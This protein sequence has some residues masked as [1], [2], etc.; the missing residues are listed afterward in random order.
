[1][2]KG[3][4]YGAPLAEEGAR[5]AFV[6]DYSRSVL[7]FTRETGVP[8][9]ITHVHANAVM[10]KGFATSSLLFDILA[11]K[12]GRVE[13]IGIDTFDGEVPES[14]F[15]LLEKTTTIWKVQYMAGWTRDGAKTQ[16]L[17]ECINR[18]AG[19]T[20][21]AIGKIAMEHLLVMPNITHLFVR[22]KHSNECERWF[23]LFPNLVSFEVDE[24][25]EIEYGWRPSAADYRAIDGMPTIEIIAGIVL[26]SA[27]SCEA[28]CA[29]VKHACVSELRRV[30]VRFEDGPE[31]DAYV[32]MCV[33]CAASNPGIRNL[34]IND[35]EYISHPFLL[36]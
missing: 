35:V 15:G 17:V 3:R 34:E 18:N 11:D 6:N 32:A 36:K 14:F 10:C 9:D 12:P 19:I 21:F 16:R 1:M 28:F 13:S 7:S 26:T 20:N 23:A 33:E 29:W 30:D 5:V 31:I 22:R 2:G 24:D 25:D 8:D 27:A 4:S